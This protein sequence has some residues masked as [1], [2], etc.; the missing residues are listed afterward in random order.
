[1]AIV[2]MKR[3]FLAALKSD[4]DN[5]LDDL[6]KLS[7]VE[8][9]SPDEGL[10]REEMAKLLTRGEK[11]QPALENEVK[12]LASIIEALER[13]DKRAKPLFSQL[14]PV[15][16][17]QAGCGVEKARSTAALVAAHTGRLSEL[18]NE[19]NRLAASIAALLPYQG[20]DVDLSWESTAKT[21]LIVGTIPAA[22]TE[23][24]VSETINSAGAELVLNI[25]NEDADNKYVFGVYPKDREEENNSAL[26]TL[27]FQKAGFRDITGTA[28]DNIK[29]I[30][31]RLGEIEQE[32]LRLDDAL[33]D[34]VS[35]L[36]DLQTAYDW[37]SIE[38]Q[39]QRESESLLYSQEV[40]F[41]E[42]WIPQEKTGR[43]EEVLAKYDCSYEVRNPAEGEEPPVMLQNP[44]WAEPFTSIT[45]LYSLPAYGTIDPTP[46]LAVF[47]F[48]FYGMMLGDAAYGAILSII[49]F[50]FVYKLKARGFVRQLCLT[51]GLSGIAAVIWGLLTG[52]IFGDVIPVVA[53]TFFDIKIGDMALWFS[54]MN[55]PIKMLIICF[56]L[57]LIHLFTGMGLKAI[58]LIKQGDYKGALYDVGFWYCL[59]IGLILLLLGSGPGKALSIIGTVG[60]ILTQG[61]DS[62]NWVLRILSGIYALYGITGYLADVLSYSRILALGLSSGVIASVFNAMGAMGGK[63][64]IGAIVFLAV[65]VFG[66]A[67][68]VALNVLGSFV[69]TARLQYVEFF[70]KFYEA[71]G[72]TFQPLAR[73]TKYIQIIDGEAR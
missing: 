59:I 20:L 51:L 55:E 46:V 28:G 65:F 73:N 16:A 48:A 64:F 15:S 53:N 25:F 27:G 57:G 71:G 22:W 21:N 41:T 1:M 10:C 19:E 12:Q 52:S 33:T 69:H 63:S 4:R 40:F 37:L 49:C 30:T 31:E 70:G 44:R 13:Y 18:K 26:K 50:T 2:T 7:C 3:L 39:K 68:N 9:S 29:Q 36:P 47:F 43:L 23:L 56:V 54:P 42:C 11:A 24:T 72:R 66:T 67:L 60:L 5:L 17:A 6:M 34:L 35:E 8:I 32:R 58:Y 45:E 61:R 38:L 14:R 62:K